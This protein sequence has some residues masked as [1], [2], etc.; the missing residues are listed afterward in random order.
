MKKTFAALTFDGYALFTFKAYDTFTARE[1]V[2]SLR[3]GSETI[4][5]VRLLRKDDMGPSGT[6][7]IPQRGRLQAYTP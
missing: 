5:R 4:S 1:I 3:K 6:A 2:G 7:G